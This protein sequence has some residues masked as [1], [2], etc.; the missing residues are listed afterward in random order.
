VGNFTYTFEVGDRSETRVIEVEALVDTGAT[1][2]RIP[3]RVLRDLGHQPK[4][5]ATFKIADGKTVEY[6]LTDVPIRI[7]DTVTVNPCMWDESD[8]QPLLGAVTL[9]SFLLAVDPI[10]QKLISVEG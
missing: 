3:G 2:C 7:G 4:R 10:E 9:E 5:R 8:A 1:F 6:D